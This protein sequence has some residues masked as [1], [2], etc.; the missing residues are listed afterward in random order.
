MIDIFETLDLD[1]GALPGSTLL[2]SSD[3]RLETETVSETQ[4][5]D[6][7]VSSHPNCDVTLS[8]DN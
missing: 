3:S 1:S 4:F 2:H 6:S 7:T 8:H 5:L